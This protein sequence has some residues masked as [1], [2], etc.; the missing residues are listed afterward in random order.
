MWL[1]LGLLLL[2]PLW[3]LMN[4]GKLNDVYEQVILKFGVDNFKSVRLKF[5]FRVTFL[6]GERVELNFYYFM[7]FRLRKPTTTNGPLSRK[8][9]QLSPI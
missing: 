2:L 9:S 6:C 1:L 4:S 8:K 7:Y 3:F 5:L